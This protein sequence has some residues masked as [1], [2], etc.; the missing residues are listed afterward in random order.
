MRLQPI[1]GQPYHHS[2]FLFFNIVDKRIS[3]STTVAISFFLFK[4]RITR[5]CDRK[6]RRR[7]VI[8]P[9]WGWVVSP[10]VSRWRPRLPNYISHRICIQFG[11]RCFRYLLLSPIWRRRL[12]LE[13]LSR[14]LYASNLEAGASGI[15]CCLQ[16][17]GGDCRWNYYP[18]PYMHPIW[19]QVLPVSLVV[20]NLEAEIAV[21]TTLS[22]LI[23]I[24]FGSRCLA[25]IAWLLFKRS[26]LNC[27]QVGAR[28]SRTLV[29]SIPWWEWVLYFRRIHCLPLEAWS[30][31][32]NR[33]TLESFSPNM[34]SSECDSSRFS[35]ARKSSYPKVVVES[36]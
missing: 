32:W 5:S 2:F 17:G 33:S 13:L 6:V 26:H 24:Q 20:S 30:R 12:P 15:S 21:G 36:A 31:Y 27:T 23:C 10:F 25:E 28:A 8:I 16:F 11:S 29:L 4:V 18:A 3:R 35:Q 9:R 14:T 22:H 7:H 1:V 34:N 19:K